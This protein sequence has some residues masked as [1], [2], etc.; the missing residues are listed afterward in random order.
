MTSRT[1]KIFLIATI[2]VLVVA[3]FAFDLHRFLTLE[4]LKER[5]Q[6]FSDYYSANRVLTVAIYFILYVVVTALSLPGDLIMS[7]AGGVLFGLWLGLLLVSFAS[8]VGATLA[9]LGA[10]FLFRDAVQRRFGEKLAAVNQGIEQ[11]GA[12]YLFTLRLVPVFPFF[13]INLI[14]GLTP[15]RTRVFYLVSQFG[16]L[17]ATLVCV[18]AGT[19]L[20]KIESAADIL[21]PGLL[22]SLA[23]LGLF[24][25]LVKKLINRLRRKE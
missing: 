7:L 20:G 10:R 14:M 1:A 3:F 23:L 19:R 13:I 4:S 24:P 2:I 5:Q 18:N 8:T 9:F 16:M 21:S 22:L 15:L 25:L 17:P 6:A 12:L 11:D